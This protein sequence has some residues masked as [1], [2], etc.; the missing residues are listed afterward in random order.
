MNSLQET[1]T[2]ALEKCKSSYSIH[3]SCIQSLRK[4]H[5]SN[6]SRFKKLF[7]TSLKK[8]LA[9]QKSDEEI[10]RLIHFFISYLSEKKNLSENDS[11]IVNNFNEFIIN[12]LLDLTEAQCKNVRYRSCRILRGIIENLSVDDQR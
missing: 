3:A 2:Q 8:I 11:K 1:I 6:P 10:D 7:I 12:Y 9:L 5:I 4:L